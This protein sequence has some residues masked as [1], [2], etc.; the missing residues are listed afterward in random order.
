MIYMYTL[1]M[2]TTESA[3]TL[4]PIYLLHS[5]ISRKALTL[6][7]ALQASKH[8]KMKMRLRQQEAETI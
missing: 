1:K 8:T 3:E 6:L 2:E 5:V 4:I 7:T